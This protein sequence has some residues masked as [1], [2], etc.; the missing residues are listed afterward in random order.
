[1]PGPDILTTEIA[2]DI[3]RHKVVALDFETNNSLTPRTGR[4]TGLGV[5]CNNKSYYFEWR[6]GVKDLLIKIVNDYERICCWHSFQFDSKWLISE[7]ITW[8]CKM[9]CTMVMWYLLDERRFGKYALKGEDGAAKIFYGLDL[10]EYKDAIQGDLFTNYTFSDYGRKDP[11][12]C[13]RLFDD[14]YLEIEEQGLKNVYW[15]FDCAVL[16]PTGQMEENGLYFNV[17]KLREMA[18]ADLEEMRSI[19]EESIKELGYRI[20]LSSPP[21]VSDTIFKNL[22]LEPLDGMEL[23]K[24][25]KY[26][27]DDDVLD[28][29]SSKYPDCKFIKIA[30]KH[31]G[32]AKN[33][34]S[35]TGKYYELAK[36]GNGYVYG[37]FKTTRTLTGRYSGEFQQF[38]RVEDDEDPGIRRAI[39]A[40]EGYLFIDAD[41][42][43]IELRLVAHV[44]EEQIMIDAFNE[45]KDI[46]QI[47]ADIWKCTRSIS[48][49]INF[50]LVY[51]GHWFKLWHMINKAMREK[52]LTEISQKEAKRLHGLYF[53][54]NKKIAAWQLSGREELHRTLCAKTL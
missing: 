42:S 34:S 40:P 38:P 8:T 24:N 12:I 49:N 16:A 6:S 52:N 50:M 36:K 22:E 28:L 14:K 51:G 23:G 44:A 45:D 26:S 9:A 48:K 39:C 29:L 7:N 35:Y 41:F 37:S 32:V 4:I 15:D 46:H 53:E 21:Q 1:M 47:Y 25:G 13:K 30:R 54:T 17:E 20:D 33:Y 43:Q 5:G 10:P 18:N 31:R 2:E 27:S 19:E 11:E 3:L